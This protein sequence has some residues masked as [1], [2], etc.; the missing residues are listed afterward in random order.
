MMDRD[1]IKQAIVDL[2]DGLGADI[3]SEGLLETPERVATMYM[4]VL[5]GMKYT[6]QDIAKMYGKTFTVDTQ[7]MVAV[8]GIQ[9]FSYCEHHLA[10]MYNMTIDVG[11]IP[12]GKVIG[13][14]KLPR[15]VEMCCKRLQLQERIGEDI[16]EVIRLATGSNDVIVMIKAHHSCMTCRG[17]KARES[18]TTTITKYGKF[19]EANTFNEFIISYR[20]TV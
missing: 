18:K 7:S 12:N 14:S 2:L 6:N 17:V 10:L 15:I 4:E 20:T 3:S 19:M 1:K 9:A 11:Y 8:K 16:A 13:L 5:E